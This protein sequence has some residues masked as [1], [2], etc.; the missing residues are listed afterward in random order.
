M[1]T[2]TMAVGLL[3]LL[4]SVA[5]GCASR[6]SD[7]ASP[8]SSTASADRAV[9]SFAFGA[10]GVSAQSRVERAVLREGGE[11]L[12]GTTEI[13]VPGEAHAFVVHETAELDSAGRLLASTSELRT[14]LRAEQVLRTVRF[15]ATNS[16]VTVRDDKGER[17]MRVSADHPW[18]YKNP[19]AD[20]A[21][22]ASD[23]TAVEA[24]IARRAA[25][26]ATGDVPRVTGI[27]VAS[28]GTFVTLASQVL[29][30]DP[31]AD[32]VVLGDEVIET[33]GEFVRALAWKGLESA[34]NA[35][36]S[37]AADCG[38]GPV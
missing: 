1:K 2:K 22:V 33:D 7:S 13:R 17:T 16:A 38:H 24:W 6:S 34:A 21:P 3:A 12:D 30:T 27:D 29:M 31:S 4:F 15:D 14:G 10:G 20:I 25:Q 36:Q 8:M 5:S 11:S 28:N 32:L 9:H 18:F 19:F 35:M 37:A 26:S 23:T